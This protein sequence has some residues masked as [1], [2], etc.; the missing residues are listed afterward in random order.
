[1]HIRKHDSFESS[2][3]EMIQLTRLM[4]QFQVL[5]LVSLAHDQYL[6]NGQGKEKVGLVLLR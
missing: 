2:N 6:E 5:L 4:C 3:L 1:M